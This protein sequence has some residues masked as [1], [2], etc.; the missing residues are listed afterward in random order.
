MKLEYK[1]LQLEAD[2]PGRLRVEGEERR[3]DVRT[4]KQM[5]PVLKD[6]VALPDS[7]PCYFMYRDAARKED[8]KAYARKELRF[9]ITILPP[10]FLGEEYNKTAGHYHP[11]SPKGF[12]YMELYEVIEGTAS[13]LMQKKTGKEVESVVLVK[14][15]K[16]DKVIIPPGYGH[17]TVNPSKLLVTANIVERNFR[18][19]Y[20]E[21]EEKHGAAYYI[22]KKRKERNE[23][24][25]LIGLDEYTAAEFNKS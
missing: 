23:N 20:A 8:R 1:S 3:P 16:G 5:R 6:E 7:T 25:P 12:G 17:V 11:M 15:K 24:Y 4:L 10:L 13:Y 22:T 9:D 19:E 2:A 14:A 18:S 21:Y